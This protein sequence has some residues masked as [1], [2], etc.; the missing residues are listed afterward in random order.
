MAKN[1]ARSSSRSRYFIF[2]FRNSI[3]FSTDPKAFLIELAIVLLFLTKASAV[4]FKVGSEPNHPN[5]WE[6][7]VV[8]A[9]KVYLSEGLTKD[10]G[11]PIYPMHHETPVEKLQKSNVYTHFFQGDSYAIYAFGKV[12]GDSQRLVL[13]SR[14]IPLFLTLIAMLFFAQE[15]RDR[16]LGGWQWGAAWVLGLMAITP[17]FYFWSSSVTG[18]GYSSACVLLGL[19]LG[20]RI[21]ETDALSPKR[22]YLFW[23]T[24]F[25]LGLI[26]I[27]LV[28]THV[29]AVC[30]APWIGALLNPRAKRV[31]P[32]F[33]LSFIVG[34]GIVAG[35][36][37]HFWQVAAFLESWS[38]AFQDQ[39]HTFFARGDDRSGISRVSAIGLFSDYARPFF[40]IGTLPLTISALFGAWLLRSKARSRSRNA[41]AVILSCIASYA[42]ILLMR[43]SAVVHWHVYPHVFALLYLTWMVVILQVAAERAE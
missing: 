24:S 12:V 35:Y 38:L 23:G 8:H 29:F 13:M 33:K 11:L 7:N 2:N 36:L 30:A 32:G 43:Q 21:S 4:A 26:S 31:L 25:V 19:M 27:Y 22:R 17:N 40:R 6:G 18:V 9:A 14:F 28:M 1:T 37:L 20:L 5:T 15:V 3:P 41:T 42:F 39:F 10:A 34:L 16:V